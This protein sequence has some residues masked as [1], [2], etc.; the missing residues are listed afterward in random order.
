M[1]L[2]MGG[3]D[4]TCCTSKI[5]LPRD[6][7][8]VLDMV[9]SRDSLVVS[10]PGMPCG[11]VKNELMQL[12]EQLQALHVQ[13]IWPLVPPEQALQHTCAK[14][15]MSGQGTPSGVTY[16]DARHV[17]SSQCAARKQG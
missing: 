14:L 13:A 12:C 16:G 7:Q 11:N 4:L 10:I 9:L 15:R 1:L 5:D 6:S 3:L 8:D 2:D 17:T